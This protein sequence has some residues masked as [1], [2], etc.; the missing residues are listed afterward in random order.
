[1]PNYEFTCLNCDE[2]F[3]RIVPMDDRDIQKCAKCGYRLNRNIA[4]NGSVWAPTST[5][6]GH[7]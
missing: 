4:F 2:T 7:K 5:N 6:G 3:D 1:M